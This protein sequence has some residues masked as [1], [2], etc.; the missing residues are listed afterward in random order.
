[1]TWNPA[2]KGWDTYVQK[3]LDPELAGITVH[4][5]TPTPACK[6]ETPHRQHSS[7]SCCGKRVPLFRHMAGCYLAAAAIS[8]AATTSVQLMSQH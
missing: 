5:D 4:T 6:V 8:C 1:M 2:S 7:R 3:R